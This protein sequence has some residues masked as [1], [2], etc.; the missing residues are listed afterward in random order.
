MEPIEIIAIVLM[1][2]AVPLTLLAFIG[3]FVVIG[4]HLA[5]RPHRKRATKPHSK[6]TELP[7]VS[8]EIELPSPRSRQHRVARS[9]TDPY[10][11][12]PDR[13]R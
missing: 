9:A 6:R 8:E 1:G 13:D 10:V 3:W 7:P 4:P 11:F 2:L 12:T 5:R